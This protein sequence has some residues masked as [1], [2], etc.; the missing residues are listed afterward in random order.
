[1]CSPTNDGEEELPSL[2]GHLAGSESSLF[3]TMD[4]Q[5]GH[6][7][8]YTNLEDSMLLSCSQAADTSNPIFPGVKVVS[9]IMYMQIFFKK[10]SYSSYFKTGGK[11]P[12]SA[13][14]Y[15]IF[16]D[17]IKAGVAMYSGNAIKRCIF[18]KAY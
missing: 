5:V 12:T 18:I 9:S 14:K 17:I 4:L 15:V 3:D 13:S 16:V 6:V 8:R 7:L 10:K 11:L 1:M 2:Y